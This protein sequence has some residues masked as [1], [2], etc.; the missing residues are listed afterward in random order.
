MELVFVGCLQKYI[1]GVDRGDD[2]DGRT[3]EGDEEKNTCNYNFSFVYRP[4]WM[5]FKGGLIEQI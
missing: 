3:K 5:Q 4:L 1:G 2:H